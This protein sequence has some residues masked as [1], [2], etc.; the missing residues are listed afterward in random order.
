MY[1]RGHSDSESVLRAV[2]GVAVEELRTVSI[3]GG[4]HEEKD[5]VLNRRNGAARDRTGDHKL[6]RRGQQ[7]LCTACGGCIHRQY[8]CA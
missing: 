8:P 1:V 7:A 2:I 5:R 3:L 4:N 6:I